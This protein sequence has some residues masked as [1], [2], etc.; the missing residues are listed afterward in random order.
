MYSFI[1]KRFKVGAAA[2]AVAGSLLAAPVLADE[3]KVG[4]L[5][6]YSGTYSWWGQE[7]DRGVEMFMAETG[8]KVGNHTITV[9]KR[10]E[11]GANPQ[12]ARQLAQELIVRDKVQYLTGGVF[13]PTVM[14][15]SDIVDQTKTPYVFVNGATSSMTNKTPYF[16]RVGYTSWTYAVPLM[17]WAYEQGAREA[18]TVIADYAPGTDIAQA[19]DTSFT[20]LGGKVTDLI[21][22][23]LGTTDFSTYLQR[24]SDSGTKHVFMFMPVGPMS[25]SFIK[26]FQD[27]GLGKAGVQLYA[28]AETQESDLPAIGDSAQ[29][30]VT[31]LHYSPYLDNPEN[32][33][34]VEKYKA[35]FGPDAI[36]SLASM[37]AY[38][39]MQ[40]IAHM[41]KA[42]DGKKDGDAA[43][44]SIKGYSWKSP[45]GPVT[46]DP[47]TR[48]ITQNIYIRK[49]QKVDGGLLGNVPVHTYEAVAEPWHAR[50][51][52]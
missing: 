35:K 5:S 7:Y 48:E 17:K 25:A 41:I 29:G 3:I 45:R 13:T 19:F 36:P 23:P 12:R 18:V 50:N 2:C 15:T 21:K 40:V 1:G 47:N 44:A 31:S 8:G 24:I 34:F 37:G 42:T 46:I 49:V 52:K 28:G 38:D 43:M 33:A 26:A 30:I 4:L 22:V 16:A 51:P 20:E 6:Q 11:G 27:R 39:A 14:G 32:K 9:V 10:D